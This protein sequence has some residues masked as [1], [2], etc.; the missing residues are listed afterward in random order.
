[1]ESI[2]VLGAGV[3]GHGIAQLCAQAGKDIRVYDTQ[4]ASL[5]KAKK[6]IHN[7]L[8]IMVE[9][10]IFTADEMKAAEKRLVYTTNLEKAVKDAEMVIEVVPEILD[11]KW[12]TYE[13]VEALVSKDTIISSNTSALTLT[14][15]TQKVKHPNRFI[16]THFFNPPVL[17]PLVEIVKDEI[18]DQRV[19]DEAY[20]LMKEIGSSPVVLKK[21]VPGFI[22]NRI[23]MAIL[24]EAWWLLENDVATA[25]D[26]DEV[27][28]ESLGFRYAFLGPLEGQDL[29]GLNTPYFVA[30]NLFP[31][32]SDVKEAPQWLKEWVDEGRLGIRSGQGFY[33]YSGN[34]GE[35]AIA[36][37]DNNFL[38]L[39][40]LRKQLKNK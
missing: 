18:T 3:M 13:K 28:K 25:A 11:L 1:M 21:E 24:R 40:K 7:S 19:I 34:A 33:E 38:E 29:S 9:K 5:D 35:E 26:I 17:V 8:A 10:E 4:Q 22:A 37:R 12:E 36:R 32:L 39:L 30:Q 2:S 27:M 31:E 20:N 23:Q 14:E 15:L 6:M 16:I